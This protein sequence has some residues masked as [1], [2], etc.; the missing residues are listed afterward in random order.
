LAAGSSLFL[1][2]QMRMAG[3]RELSPQR[4]IKADLGSS[5]LRMSPEAL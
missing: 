1:R 2:L 3:Y 4:P 5:K